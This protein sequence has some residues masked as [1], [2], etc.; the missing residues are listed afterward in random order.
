MGFVVAVGGLWAVIDAFSAKHFA[1]RQEWEIGV[2]LAF[3]V[4]G[5]LIGLLED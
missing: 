4:V 5:V 2:G 1:T 3:V